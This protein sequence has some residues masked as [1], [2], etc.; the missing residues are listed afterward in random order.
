[1]ATCH[2]ARTWQQGTIVEFADRPDSPSNVDRHTYPFVAVRGREAH[3][4]STQ[5]IIDA[6][7]VAAGES[8]TFVFRTLEYYYSPDLLNTPYETVHIVDVEATRGWAH[9]DDMLIDKD[10]EVHILYRF[11]ER[12]NESTPSPLMHAFGAPGGPLSHVEFSSDSWANEGRFWEAPNGVLFVVRVLD[13]ELV[14]ERVGEDGRRS[15]SSGPLGVHP[16]TGDYT[17]SRVFLSTSRG[18]SRGAPFLEGL[19]QTQSADG[20][21]HVHSFHAKLPELVSDVGGDGV[22]DFGDFLAFA[23]SF[24]MSRGQNGFLPAADTNADATVDFSDFLEFARG[25]SIGTE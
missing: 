21:R 12:E 11:Q 24:N 9:N 1:M 7:K 18:S 17:S 5:D 6:D 15:G 3:V 2:R 10:G 22:V 14:A 23:A 4:F 20:T 25:Y 13:D 8:F 16:Q 19:Y